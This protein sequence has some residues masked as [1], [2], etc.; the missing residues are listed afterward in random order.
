MIEVQESM[1]ATELREKMDDME[2]ASKWYEKNKKGLTTQ[3]QFKLFHERN[4]RLKS[5]HFFDWLKHHYGHPNLSATHIESNRYYLEA[6][7]QLNDKTFIKWQYDD[8][9][10]SNYGHIRIK[11]SEWLTLNSETTSWNYCEL[12]IQLDDITIVVAGTKTEQPEEGHEDDLSS[13]YFTREI[14]EAK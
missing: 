6:V 1:T 11:D 2:N 10:L 14:K 4:P 9:H 13:R 5:K 12:C 3:W 8:V 7:F